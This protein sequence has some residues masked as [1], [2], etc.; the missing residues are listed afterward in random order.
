MVTNPGI[1]VPLEMMCRV[2]GEGQ[3]TVVT[4]GKTRGT[5]LGI[6]T[7]KFLSLLES[8]PDHAISVADFCNRFYPVFSAFGTKRNL[9]GK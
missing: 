1:V 8:S 7:V 5:P 3:V 2:E 4:E 9:T 6:H